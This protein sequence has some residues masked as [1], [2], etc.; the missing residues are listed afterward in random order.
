MAF[1][2]I[3]GGHG[4]VARGAQQ[5][6]RADVGADLTGSRRGVQERAEYGYEAL[7]EVV[8]QAVVGPVARVEGGAEPALRADED[9]EAL[10]P[11]RERLGRLVLRREVNAV[12]PAAPRVRTTSRFS[13]ASRSQVSSGDAPGQSTAT[14]SSLTLRI[15]ARPHSSRSRRTADG[16]SRVRS[17]RTFGSTTRTECSAPARAVAAT[18][19]AAGATTAAS[20]PAY[21]APKRPTSAVRSGS[22][23][24]AVSS[25]WKW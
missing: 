13:P 23:K 10:Q 1:P 6:V 16:W 22:R 18:A 11:C 14:S 24:V 20:P 8:G 25:R 5:V 15:L 17:S 4:Q 7:L 21:T 2:V 12:L 9:R 19:P 3:V